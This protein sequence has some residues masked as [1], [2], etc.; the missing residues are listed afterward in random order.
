MSP[1]PSS[2]LIPLRVH[3]HSPAS[4]I[5]VIDHTLQMRA[6]GVGTLET[7]LPPGFY[8][9]RYRAGGSHGD[10]L[11]ELSEQT[12]PLVIQGEAVHYQSS[13]PIEGTSTSRE[14]H[15][16]P[17]ERLSRAMHRSLGAGSQLF[18][19]SR[20]LR[21]TVPGESWAG[22]SV[23]ALDGQ[24][25]ADLA[26]GECD[27]VD[28]FGGIVLELDPGTYRIQ[29]D[30]G[31]QGVY[32]MFVVTSFGWQTQVYGL[33]EDF[34]TRRERTRRMAL[35]SASILMTRPGMGFQQDSR[36]LRLAD[37]ARLGLA[38]GRKV[39]RQSELESLLYGKF[40][41]PMLGIYGLHLLLMRGRG[42]D[43][44]LIER[45][46]ANM[47]GILGLHPDVLALHLRSGAGT[48]PEDLAFPTPPMLKS[49]WD[50]IL[51]GTRR[52]N[53]LVPPGSAS[54]LLADGMLPSGPWLLR[55]LPRAEIA[56]P[57]DDGERLSFAASKRL[58]GSM[59]TALRSDDLAE[60]VR[61]M[62][63][64][65]GA[66]SPLERS[67]LSASTSLSGGAELLARGSAAA[68]AAD[69]SRVLE[70]VA[71]PPSAIARSTLSAVRKLGQRGLDL[72]SLGIDPG[73]V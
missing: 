24:R 70:Q 18:L 21:P 41:N 67:I 30:T 57:V 46:M 73:E 15:A 32:E 44:G 7:E 34:S 29:V 39:I 14:T 51:Q 56:R 23:H 12:G 42:V 2:P 9:I 40:E 61:L 60:R 1:S 27:P 19:F 66:F 6:S 48:P 55:R 22:V 47:L 3:G 58:I 65:P 63:S 71:A 35:R 31:E 64:S 26:E 54:D 25:L 8:K 17:A 50:L 38:G 37:M 16:Y 49:S 36:D 10:Q 69:T 59:A 13:V 20:D 53:A 68:V 45:V 28:G 5:F 11:I 52:R 72:Q 43:H 33:V 4:E 62:T